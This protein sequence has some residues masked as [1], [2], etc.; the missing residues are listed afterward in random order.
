MDVAAVAV[1]TAVVGVLFF[2]NEEE[3]CESFLRIQLP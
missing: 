2:E 1:Q 3:T